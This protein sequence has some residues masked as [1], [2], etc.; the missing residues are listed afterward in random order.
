MASILEHTLATLKGLKPHLSEAFLRSDNA[1]CYHTAFLLLSLPSLGERTGVRIARYDFSKPQAGKDICDCRIAS[2]KSHIR[3]FVN[4]GNDVQTAAH[5]KASIESHGGVK[6]CYESV[7]K[8]QTMSQT[9][10][11]HTMTGIQALNN[12]FYEGGGLRAWRAYDIGPEKFF[13][14]AMIARFGTPQGATNI[15]TVLPFGS[16]SVEVGTFITARPLPSSS[17]EPRPSQPEP[18]TPSEEGTEDEDKIDFACPEEGCIK[19]YQS[20]SALQKHLDVR[21]HHL[22]LECETQYDQIKRK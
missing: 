7:C 21:K 10:H 4:E 1:G 8:V 6:G 16:P 15:E 2:V 18:T 14:S 11:K 9:M 22:K 3:R 13:P 19:V 12:F 20:F 17:V 5:M